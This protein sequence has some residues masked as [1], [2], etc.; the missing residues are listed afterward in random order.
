M[1]SKVQTVGSYAHMD[2]ALN[3]LAD[4][5][6][7]LR[8]GLTNH[9][10]MAAEALCALGQGEAVLPWIERYRAG[11]LPRPTASAPIAVANW[12]AA[13]GQE[14]RFA[15]WSDLFRRQ[16]DGEPWRVA[17]ERWVN[18]LMPGS[19]AAATHGL[20]RVG[21]AVRSLAAADTTARRRELADGLAYWAATFRELPAA[22]YAAPR[23]PPRPAVERIALVPT[24][25]R[26][27]AG[28]I[29]SALAALDD[30]PAFAPVID[31]LDVDGDLAPL[32]AALVELFAR[33]YLANARDG[34]TTI[35]F[36]H[37]VTSLA[38]LGNLLP[39]LDEATGRGALRFT[40]QAAA[41]LYAAIG[42]APPIGGEIAPAGGGPPA[43]IDQAVAHGDEHVIKF[44]EACLRYHA[45]APSPAYPAA[46]QHALQL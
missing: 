24:A 3:I 27:F 25:R 9:A 2:E 11:M 14:H 45:L 30:W 46:I 42:S 1:G 22:P 10:P 43:L 7:D 13:L 31:W 17:L 38:A 26:R 21:H 16:L 41:A 28:T 15:D 32:L 44:T 33:I 29:D 19:A 39:H 36:I 6:P 4:Y 18:R 40:W 12:R 5:G 37:G 8:S 20:I 34:L 35:V 23:L